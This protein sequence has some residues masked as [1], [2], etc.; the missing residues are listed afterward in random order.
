MTV[1]MPD[2]LA[3][4]AN[5][6]S[7][8]DQFERG[9]LGALLNCTAKTLHVAGAIIRALGG[10][11]VGG[12][13]F[14]RPV[15]AM[16]YN[17]ICELVA[18]NRAPDPQ[19]VLGK[20][21]FPRDF[22]ITNN[23]TLVFD[24]F[25]EG[26][27][28]QGTYYAEKVCTA[29]GQ[30]N[31]IL[32]LMRGIQKMQASSLEDVPHRLRDVQ[33]EVAGIQ[34]KRTDSALISLANLTNDP[35]TPNVN[36]ELVDW[37]EEVARTKEQGQ[38]PGAL[39]GLADLDRLLGGG[40][41]GEVC[42]MAGRPGMAKTTC[43]VEWMVNTA[44]RQR[45][46]VAIFSMEMGRVQIAVKIL[47][48]QARIPVNR[49]RSGELTDEDWIKAAD[50]IEDTY[51]ETLRVY[52]DDR[53]A[54]TLNDIEGA[55]VALNAELAL[56][57]GREIA[58]GVHPD[59]ACPERIEM[60]VVDYLQ[61]A[62]GSRE[63]NGNRE[64]EVAGLSKGFKE[65]AKRIRAFFLV[66]SQLNRGPENRP[67]KRPQMSDMRESGS[68]EQDADYVILLHRDDYYD[69]ESPRAGEIDYI[70]AK[71]RNGPTDTITAIAQLNI[72]K[73]TGTSIDD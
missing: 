47:A 59:E 30:R 33:E 13:V 55:L 17:N 2:E 24:L 9:V 62:K 12:S 18:A 71:H 66:L 60:V 28:S 37:L 56:Q 1:T 67:D 15:H 6:T 65:L 11:D 42:V 43:A 10:P 73:I 16:I 34:F 39:S 49:L 21:E 19:S 29:A 72:S 61:L 35:D 32:S 36:K 5:P 57:R 38:A 3:D 4:A 41:E 40:K 31:M 52:I 54:R 69:K 44:R 58:N 20:F 53:P 63:R 22:G 26:N 23:G 25:S 48:S 14:Y 27:V 70:V 45:K 51:R 50:F 64:Q 46:A 8:V 7:A 68:V